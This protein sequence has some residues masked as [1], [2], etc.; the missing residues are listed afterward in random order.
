MSHMY[1]PP[2]PYGPGGPAS[3]PGPPPGAGYPPPNE[4]YAVPYPYGPAPFPPPASYGAR[5]VAYLI[6]GFIG[7]VIFLGLFYGAMGAGFWLFTPEDGG[8]GEVA[9]IVT[10]LVM[11]VVATAASFSYVWI[12][13]A[14]SGRTLGKRAAGI[15]LILIKTGE[16]PGLG[17]SAGRQ[18]VA[19]LLASV[20]CIGPMLDLL[21]PLWDEPYRQA[22]HDKAVGTRVVRVPEG[23]AAPYAAPYPGGTGPAWPGTGGAPSGTGGWY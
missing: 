11:F 17:L 1:G 6:D 3:G 4:P 23:E 7:A 16:P 20:S 21:W 13:H 5:V 14:R 9:V 22:V 18:L 12:P 15:K 8:A 19:L 2:P 10:M